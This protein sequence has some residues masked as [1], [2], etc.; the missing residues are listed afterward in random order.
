MC[1]I[2][3]PAWCRVLDHEPVKQRDIARAHQTV[4]AQPPKQR[5][6]VSVGAI[7]FFLGVCIRCERLGRV[8]LRRDVHLSFLTRAN[9]DEN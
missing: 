8:T 4:P 5:R 7:A 3:I 1:L 6:F 9:S 2:N